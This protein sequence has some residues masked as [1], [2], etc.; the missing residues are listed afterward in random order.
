[1]TESMEDI[2]AFQSVRLGSTPVIRQLIEETG[3]IEHIDKRSPVKKEDCNVPVGTRIAALI[4]N[5]LSDRK[6]LFKVEEFYEKQDVELL[7]G[8]GVTARDFNDDALGRALDALYH[9]GLEKVCMHSIQGVQ[10]CMNLSWEGIHADTTSFVYTGAPKNDPDDDLLK[11]V[12]G[13]TKDHRPDVPQ[14]KFG[15]ATSPEG[16]PIY[17]DV[18]NG[19]QDD[20]IWNAK[21]M[22]A[23]RR[24]YEPDQLEQAIFIADSALVT[25]DNLKTVQGNEE[26]PA[27]Q[28]I[29][30]L[31]ENFKVVQ[32][33][34]EKAL[35][36]DEWEDIGRFVNRKGAASYH[37]Y[38]AK[39]KLHGKT[40]RFLVVQ[41]DEMDGRQKK[42]IDNRRRKAAMV[43]RAKRA[44]KPGFC[45]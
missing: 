40:Y 44:G 21:V 2:P 7:F 20:K 33:L 8:P 9:A 10:A 27:F 5:Q 28:F 16:A 37:I 31:P 38:P 41:S 6:P 24:W 45:L 19:N 25:E 15:L 4:I 11:I 18:L 3:I 12:R 13:H 17:A 23:L 39:E 26:Q 35:E 1:M 22:K 32:T 36:N 29:S 43:K 34:K 14:I 30:R 42:K